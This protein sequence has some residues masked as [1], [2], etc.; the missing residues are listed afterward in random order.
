MSWSAFTDFAPDTGPRV[1]FFGIGAKDAQRVLKKVSSE[2]D[3]IF[4]AWKDG[5]RWHAYVKHKQR[6]FVHGRGWVVGMARQFAHD[7][8]VGDVVDRWTDNGPRAQL[9]IV[10]WTQQIEAGQ[11]AETW[12]R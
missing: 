10:V 6:G 7:F 11:E 1:V 5:S 2:H 12:T 3:R 4:Y 8:N 9:A